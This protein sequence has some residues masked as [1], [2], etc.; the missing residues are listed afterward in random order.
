MRTATVL[1]WFFNDSEGN[2]LS[3][4]VYKFSVVLIY[5]PSTKSHSQAVSGGI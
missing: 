4:T 5:V 2:K 1:W 3:T